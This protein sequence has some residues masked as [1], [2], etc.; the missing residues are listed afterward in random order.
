MARTLIFFA[1]LHLL[2]LFSSDK[3]VRAAGNFA[4]FICAFMGLH[5][6]QLAPVAISRPEADA[7]KQKAGGD[8]CFNAV[9]VL[10][11][12]GGITT[13]KRPRL[14]VFKISHATNEEIFAL[15]SVLP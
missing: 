14:M 5:N 1:A 11:R 4:P 13:C 6:M 15:L 12:L 8:A 7:L 10:F 9:P 3:E 2:P